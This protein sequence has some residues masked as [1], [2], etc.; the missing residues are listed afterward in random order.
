METTTTM[1]VVDYLCSSSKIGCNPTKNTG[2]GTVGVNN[3][4]IVLAD[5]AVN[6]FNYKQ[7]YIGGYLVPNKTKQGLS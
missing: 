2:F 6:S 7:I 3:R 1:H 5:I 4:G